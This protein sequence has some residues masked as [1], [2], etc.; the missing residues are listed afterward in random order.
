MTEEGVETVEAKL[1]TMQRRIAELEEELATVRP[2]ARLCANAS[3]FIAEVTVRGEMLRLNRFAPGFEP[4]DIIGKTI[5]DFTLPDHR[6][7]L[8]SCLERVVA[9]RRP[10]GVTTVAAGA[11]GQA[12]RFFTL[13]SPILEHGEVTTVSLVATEISP[14]T[15]AM[16]A[17]EESESKLRLVL[18]ATRMGTFVVDPSHPDM[19]TIGD[20]RLREIGG[21][22]SLTG[23]ALSTIH[24]DDLPLVQEGISKVLAEPGAH[25]PYQIRLRRP[26]GSTRWIEAFASAN[27]TATGE[28]S[29]VGGVL[30]VTNRKQLEAA[31]ARDEKLESIG[32]LAGG[33]A[34]DFNNM[35]TVIYSSVTLALEAVS[36]RSSVAEDLREIR[37]A[38]DRSAA[39]TR[40]ILAFAR[41]QT[42]SPR[43]LDP[44]GIVLDV[45]KLLR[46]VLG[47]DIELVTLLEATTTIRADRHQL[48]QVLL[49]LATNARHAMRNGG[50]FTLI[51]SDVELDPAAAGLLAVEP[52]HGV[53]ITASD[54]GEGMTEE[55][56][57]RVFEP[58]FTTKAPGT[59]T[60][61]GLSTSYGVIR[62][63]GGAITVASVPTGGTTFEI[64][65][66]AAGEAS[67]EGAPVSS[68]PRGGSERVLVV[69]DEPQLRRLVAETLRR[70]G[71]EVL[72]ASNGAEALA[73][74]QSRAKDIQLVVSDHVMP[75][76]SGIQ[77]ARKLREDAVDVR[78]LLM[79]G[80]A[81][82]ASARDELELE[83]LAKPFVPKELAFKVREVLERPKG[84]PAKEP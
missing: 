22:D 48:E 18:G 67:V 77:L 49:N 61:L 38:A 33:I 69:E 5:F 66:P 51:T 39:L 14:A 28:V 37:N 4:K 11:E 9:T 2:L 81:D 13:L 24:P 17:L 82:D 32:R 63:H 10:D 35:L 71:Y 45:D 29:I 73:V 27:R 83:F 62:K 6:E 43:V 80:Y 1:A 76:M 25:G 79:S 50:R 52:G 84:R 12:T 59:G 55:V 54:T 8:R 3:A 68:K 30:D 47:E 78:F 40:Q 42:F 7:A 60:G 31:I 19:M 70:Q 56:R 16:R 36:P 46:R 20:E 75:Q 15:Q 57:L 72:D 64:F 65:L 21:I 53:R 23:P 74:I 34:H 44:N 26:D 41:E 58:F